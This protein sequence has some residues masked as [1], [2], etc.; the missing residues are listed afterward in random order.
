MLRLNFEDLSKEQNTIIIG[1]SNVLMNYD[2]N[3]MVEPFIEQSQS[4]SLSQFF[5]EFARE[6][7]FRQKNNFPNNKDNILDQFWLNF[8][9]DDVTVRK[10]SDDE[11]IRIG[12]EEKSHFPIIYE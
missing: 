6:F 4:R 9:T 10:P 2:I 11:I 3:G 5:R 7:G 1:D 12:K 8:R